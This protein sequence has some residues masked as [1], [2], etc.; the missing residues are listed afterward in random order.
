MKKKLTQQ[1]IET[2]LHGSLP[3]AIAM[4]AI[5]VAVN[6]FL[7]TMYNLTDTFWLGHIGRTQLS[8]INLVT[9]AQNIV[10]NLGSGIT[11]AGSVLIS[12]YIGADKIKEARKLASEIYACA[13]LFSIFFA[14]FFFLLT[15]LIVG[16]LGADGETASHAITYLRIVILDMPLLFT[17]NIFQATSQS[18]GDTVKP[19]LLNFLGIIINLFLDP[20]FMV[21][22]PLGT[23]GAALATLLAKL[24]P[25]LIALR[26]LLDRE[27][28]IYADFNDFH[29]NKTDLK[30]ILQVG[31][32]TAIGSSTMQLGFLLMSKNVY[33]YGNSA[34]SAYGIGNKVNSLITLPVNGIGSATATIVGQNIGAGQYDRAE[35]GYKL[36]RNI[37]V[38]FLFLGGLIL[39]RPAVSSAITGIFSPYED[40]VALSSDFLS[41]MALYS[42]TNGVYNTTVGLFQGSGHTKINMLVDVS[43]LWIFRFL[44]LYICES[45]LHMGVRSVWYCVVVSNAISALILYIVYLTGI[46]KKSAISTIS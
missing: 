43:R 23:A 30:N 29:F 46:W 39:S 42:F 2:I 17:I 18:Q 8:A 25:M 7:Q 45:F 27:Q 15:P 1:N 21:I 38:I 6:S 16:W 40:V 4:L 12:Q 20:L 32:P 33:V 19:M 28:T 31:L 44:T 41:I 36:S 3:R 35:K 14:G 11:V 26:L 34:M 5:P 24:P 22:I 10:L 13:M 37:C 9:P